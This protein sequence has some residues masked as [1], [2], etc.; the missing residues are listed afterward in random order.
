MPTTFL[1]PPKCPS[2]VRKTTEEASLKRAARILATEIDFLV[3]I[4]YDTLEE[5]PLELQRYTAAT[6]IGAHDEV[7]LVR[8]MNLARFQAAR[9]RQRL[10]AET[11]D[12]A[13]MDEIERLLERA[14]LIRN[15]L[16]IVF[17]KLTQSIARQFA[18]SRY[19]LD[20]LVS[21]GQATLMS[22]IAKFDPERGFRFSTYATHAVRR[23]L[24]R[25]L[26]RRQR[27]RET[28]VEC[29]HD[30]LLP[31]P[32][33]WTFAYEQ[34]LTATLKQAERLLCQLPPRDRYILRS[35]YGWGREFECRTLQ[36]IADELGVSRERVRQL[37][38]RS[39]Q[40]LRELATEIE[41]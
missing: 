13:A 38:A 14:D 33:R 31:D 16:A 40:K 22:A 15:R 41:I 25:Y 39:L 32:R 2:V 20:E 27:D 35:R 36:D 5:E 24:M 10:G 1:D 4:P 12:V 37:E 28:F 3:G 18:S 11:P 8:Q 6:R 26:Q 23:R 9:L 19:P 17:G 7:R 34:W 29:P 21:E 30:N